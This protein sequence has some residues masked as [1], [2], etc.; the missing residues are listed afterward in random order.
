MSRIECIRGFQ[1]WTASRQF[2]IWS[3]SAWEAMVWIEFASTAGSVSLGPSFAAQSFRM[4]NLQCCALSREAKP[5]RFQSVEPIPLGPRNSIANE[6]PS[7]ALAACDVAARQD[8]SVHRHRF[9]SKTTL[10]G[11][12]VDL[13][14]VPVDPRWDR[15]RCTCGGTDIDG[16]KTVQAPR[17]THDCGSL[18][19]HRDSVPGVDCHVVDPHCVANNQ[20]WVGRCQHAARVNATRRAPWNDRR[21]VLRSVPIEPVAA[22]NQLSVDRPVP[23]RLEIGATSRT[24][25]VRGRSRHFRTRR[26][27]PLRKAGLPIEPGDPASCRG[28]D[29]DALLAGDWPIV[30]RRRVEPPPCLG[31]I[32]GPEVRNQRK[33]GNQNREPRVLASRSYGSTR[34]FRTS[35]ARIANSRNSGLPLC[36]A[37]VK[38]CSARSISPCLIR[39]A[40]SP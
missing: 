33:S 15:L 21:A 14:A 6:V 34:P 23:F 7:D 30:R 32:V 10:Q 17:H 5:D 19:R 36:E 31:P 18:R 20:R 26:L 38:C 27:A 4:R 24:A 2:A 12:D 1:P 3:P 13:Q 8:R 39:T 29:C 9:Y 11:I 40:P 37:V 35:A 16:H 22:V 28:Q 25:L